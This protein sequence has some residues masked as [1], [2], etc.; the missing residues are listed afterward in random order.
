ML[1]AYYHQSVVDV[2][3][4]LL[5]KTPLLFVSAQTI[6][7][8]SSK[9][10]MD[11]FIEGETVFSPFAN[12]DCWIIL[13]GLRLRESAWRQLARVVVRFLSEPLTAEILAIYEEY[14]YIYVCIADNG[15][16]S[17]FLILRYLE[18]GLS[19]SIGSRWVRQQLLNIF[20]S[21][22]FLRLACQQKLYLDCFIVNEKIDPK[23]RGSTVNT[24]CN[25]RS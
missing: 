17:F 12:K 3:Y 15:F 22:G 18:T 13:S 14:I 21:L 6:N 8:W 16:F 19:N 1:E 20:P 10:R 11:L 7:S 25:L 24:R 4:T 5:R 2:W 23:F 9:L